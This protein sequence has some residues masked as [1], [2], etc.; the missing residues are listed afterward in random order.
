MYYHRI[1]N[2]NGIPSSV[3]EIGEDLPHTDPHLRADGLPEFS[4]VTIEKC[5]ATIGKQALDVEKT[6]QRCEALLQQPADPNA[7]AAAVDLFADVLRPIEASEAQLEITWGL[8]KCLYL[9]NS[10]RMPT[11]SYMQINERARKA[12]YNKFNSPQL[13]ATVMAALDQPADTFDAQQRRLLEKFEREG[14]LNGVALAASERAVL[15]E[16]MEKLRQLRARY[17]SNVDAAVRKFAHTIDDYAVVRDFPTDVLQ[18][19]APDAAQPTEGPWTVTLAPSVYTRF[20]EHCAERPLRWTVWQAQTRKCSGFTDKALTNSVHLEEIRALRRRQAQLLGYETFADMSM[21]TKMAGSVAEVRHVLD[22]LRSAA[23]PAQQRELDELQAFAATAG[24]DKKA[25]ALEACDVPFWRRKLMRA[26]HRFDEDV[27][28]EYFPLPRVLDGAFG[29]FGDL[30]GVRIERRDAVSAW[31]ADVQFYDVFEATPGGGGGGG[32]PIA[33][34]YLDLYARDADKLRQRNGNVVG[35]R[36]RDGGGAG[37]TTTA[38]R[39]IPLAALIFDFAVPLYGKPSLLGAGD[40]RALFARF[41]HGLQHLLTRVRYNDLAGMSNIEWDAV[42]VS[43]HVASGLLRNADVLTRLSGH[44]ASGERLPVELAQSVGAAERTLAGWQL[45]QELYV[46][47]L[48]L[49]LNARTAFWLEVVRD[50]WPK[51]QVLALDK[52]DA[53]P[54]SMVEC[55]SGSWAA[56]YYGHVWSRVMA[57]DVC[58][59]FDEAAAEPGDA[60]AA[61]RRVGQRYR[62]TFL[63]LGGAR[64][65]AEVFRQFRGRDPSTRPL[66]RALGL[67]GAAAAASAVDVPTEGTGSVDSKSTA[68]V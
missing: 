16:T 64:H 6:V 36:Q 39:S 21:A 56:A 38:G 60:A 55:V 8:A 22:D 29:V 49:E 17:Q 27:I 44:F 34:F 11:K 66:L 33:G 58:E 48:D 13:Y 28:R 25:A 65:A 7:P 46:A 12:R 24:G 10:S 9:G 26:Q 23:R 61:V 1:A 42:G 31:H 43:A 4:H 35:V 45:S 3:P 40:V 14:R 57:A 67:E 30:F 51:Y 32:E 62:E 18:S 41:G 63:A 59:A 54:C 5:I 47:A 19:M 50:L 52:R 53:H 68:T 37:Q 20:L 15:Y 2:R